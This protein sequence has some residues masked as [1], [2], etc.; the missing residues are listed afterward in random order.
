MLPSVL[1][2]CSGQVQPNSCFRGVQAREASSRM[3]VHSPSWFMASAMG[4]A[5]SRSVRNRN[6]ITAAGTKAATPMTGLYQRLRVTR[7]S[8]EVRFEVHP[9]VERRDLVGVAVEREGLAL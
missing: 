3:R 7:S 8:L 9:G 1:R 6:A 2:T 5:P 4:L